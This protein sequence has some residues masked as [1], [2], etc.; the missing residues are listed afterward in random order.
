MRS[1]RF[2]PPMFLCQQ[3]SREH[4]GKIQNI[5]KLNGIDFVFCYVLN[6][7]AMLSRALLT[8]KH[9]GKKAMT[10]LGLV[11]KANPTF[12]SEHFFFGQDD[13]NFQQC[14]EGYI[15]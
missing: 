8:K 10:L 4:G 9:A 12:F 6:F 13:P 1:Q 7:T 14:G 11:L 2:I 15:I 3:I 5:T